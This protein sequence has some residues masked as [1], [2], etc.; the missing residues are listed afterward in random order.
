MMHRIVQENIQIQRKELTREEAIRLFQHDKLKLALLADIPE[1]DFITLYEQGD[2]YDLCRGRM[3]PQ[4]VN[5][6]TFN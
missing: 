1:D 3:Y 6:S 4:Q 5:Y 2:F